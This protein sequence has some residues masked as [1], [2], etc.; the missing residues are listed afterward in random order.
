MLI[1]QAFLTYDIP[2]IFGKYIKEQQQPAP[3]LPLKEQN[4]CPL[5][6]FTEHTKIP[7]IISYL[8]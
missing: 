7:S 2:I 3:F 4:P 8:F 6:F 5:T 1:L